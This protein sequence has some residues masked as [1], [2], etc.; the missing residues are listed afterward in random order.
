MRGNAL[1]KFLR[2][3]DL[4]SRPQGATVEE[5]AEELNVDKRTAYR[6]LEVLQEMNFPVIDEKDPLDGRRIRKKLLESFQNKL[7]NITVP[8]IHFSATEI[9]A[10]FL[11]KGE[12]KIYKGTDVEKAIETAFA[13]IAL[14]APQGLANRL[15]RIRNLF[16]PL[17]RTGKDYSDKEQVIESLTDAMMKNLTCTIIYHSYG[18]NNKKTYR[19]DPLHFFENNG[20]LYLFVNVTRYN[21]IRI[22]AVDRIAEVT[23][24]QEEFDYPKDFSPSERLESAFTLTLDDELEIIVRFSPNQARYIKERKW[25]NNQTLHEEDNGSLLLTMTTS[26]RWSVKSWIMSYGKD[27]EVLA[28]VDLREEIAEEYRVLAR[29]YDD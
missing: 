21:D 7:P 23:L 29:Q 17:S 27:A 10:L 16:L 22:L 28:P 1:I 25:S 13:K 15:D 8:S 3:V 12:E 5:L 19:I 4:L 11:L 20:G 24:S 14:F 9:I 26:G 6:Q 2:V 18:D